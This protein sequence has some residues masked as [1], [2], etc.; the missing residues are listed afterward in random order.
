MAGV[1]IRVDFRKFTGFIRQ[2]ERAFIS[3]VQ[4]DS[5]KMALYQD[6]ANGRA[7]GN[8][9]L[10]A[11]GEDT[12]ATKASI[13]AV[14]RGKD[15]INEPFTKNGKTHWATGIIGP[16]GIYLN[17]ED[18]YGGYGEFSITNRINEYDMDFDTDHN[19]NLVVYNAIL[20]AVEDRLRI[21]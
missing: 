2:T 18:S 5:V 4:D 21:D 6:I 12:G 19:N 7:G 16:K 9:L 10:Y 15:I 1:S 13:E 20:K 17:P 11:K 3:S 14:Q 8:A